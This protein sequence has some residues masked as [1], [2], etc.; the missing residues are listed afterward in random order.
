VQSTALAG[1]SSSTRAVF[2]GGEGSSTFNTIGYVTIASTG[3]ATAF[4]DLSLA[5]FNLCCAS[6]AH[7][8][9]Q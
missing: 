6:N 1:S 8:G 4:G 7:G 9:L 5:R 3:N 2:G